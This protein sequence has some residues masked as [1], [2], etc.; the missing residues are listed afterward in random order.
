V[1]VGV[2]PPP[3]LPEQTQPPIP[4]YGYV[5]TPGYWGWNAAVNDYY[6][7][8]GLWAM[9]PQIGVLWTPPWWGWNDGVYLFN[10]GYWGP[11]IGF[12]GG[13]DYGFGYFGHGYDGGY[14][15]GRTFFYNRQVN[16]IGSVHI[17]AVY[18]QRVV[19]RGAARAVSYSGGPGGVRA[20]P[21]AQEQAAAHEVHVNATP[22]QAAHY[23]TAA[24]SPAS[25][26]GVNHGHPIMAAAAGAAAGAVAM[27]AL[28]H[29]G[30]AAG[31]HGHAASRE[32]SASRVTSAHRQGFAQ[33]AH[34]HVLPAREGRESGYERAQRNAYDGPIRAAEPSHAYAR[35]AAAPAFRE[36]PMRAA[37]APENRGSGRPSG[38]EQR[39]RPQ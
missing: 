32:A 18:D 8:P 17:N 23:Q 12:Y 14:W 30:G 3:R 35:P 34:R 16:N 31:A 24:M 27:H 33:S 7:V 20:Q 22:S 28:A 13:I 9:P 26:A 29:H 25:R 4:G 10:A 5:W 1:A 2:A 38:E 11:T 39:R 21:T 37:A 6:W 15:R 36:Q 19:D